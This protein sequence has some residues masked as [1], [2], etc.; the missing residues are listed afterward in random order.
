MPGWKT[1]WDGI[2]ALQMDI[3]IA[4]VTAAILKEALDA[5]K[6]ARLTILEHMLKTLPEPKK[7]VSA[8]AP[9]IATVNIPV[10]KI[11]ELIGPGG[12]IIK[13][14]IKETGCEVDVDDDGRVVISGTD[15]AKLKG[16]VDWIS[17]LTRE[18]VVGEEFD[19]KVVRVEAYGAFVELLPGRD[20][21]VHVSRLATSFVADPNTIVK[22][23]D[24]LH[25]RVREIDEQ[26]RVSLTA[27]TPEQEQQ[28]AQNRPQ[29]GGFS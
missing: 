26:G 6:K 3:K 21:L 22:L 5:A 1:I 27:L 12:R 25:V 15:A 28:A 13:K 24:I 7:Q 23:G 19:G 29:G 10:E 2:T 4:G 8:F 18:F 20:G 14:I 16:A 9:K 17:G 11:G